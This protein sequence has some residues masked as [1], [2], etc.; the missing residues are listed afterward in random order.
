MLDFETYFDSEFSLRSTSTIEY[1]KDP[2]FEILCLAF[3]CFYG[4]HLSPDPY[5][6][7]GEELVETAI[8]CWQKT[9]GPDL[10]ACTVL[11]QNAQ[12]D[13]SILAFK[14][15]VYPKQVIDLLGLARAWNSRCKND[16]DHQAKRWGLPPKGETKDFAGVTLRTRFAKAKGRKKGPK[17][18]TQV[19]KMTPEQRAALEVYAN[20]DVDL[21]WRLFE[22]LLPRLSRPKFEL[23]VMQDTLEMFTKPSI[24]VDYAKGEDLVIRMNAELDRVM[25]T[26]GVTDDP[27]DM[28]NGK[29]AREK[30]SGDKSFEDMLFAALEACGDNAI[31]YIKYDKNHKAILA[32]AQTDIQR[33][34]LEKHADPQVRKLMAA[35]R[36]LDAWPKHIIR[37]KKI[38]AQARA[39]GGLLPVPLKY[40]GAHT[41][42]DSGG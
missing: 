17:L 41:G 12:F 24:A 28:K 14:Y 1:I 15:G 25:A 35:R 3:N 23:R 40:H 16:L 6:P 38:M 21:E 19:P 9:Y 30:I 33:E 11:M 37:T 32:I 29:T 22:I 26:A 10:A 7:V 42:R 31:K 5:C 34:E 18:P 2:R 4:P 36:A 39:N 8:R 27:E 13:A 20:L